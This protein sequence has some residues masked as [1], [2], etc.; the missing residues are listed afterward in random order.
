M[1]DIIKA[2]PSF[3]QVAKSPHTYMLI[4]SVGLLWFFVNKFGISSEQVNKNCEAEKKELRFEINRLT[5]KN[6]HLVEA[7]LVKNG[8]IDA[9]KKN[10]DSLV[11][12]KVGNEA[13]S[14]IR[15]SK[16]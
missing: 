5:T 2:D 13:K 8:I 4:V 16:K 7:L 12:E 3:S 6:D 11:R 9:I 10:T 14:I 1:S 15:K